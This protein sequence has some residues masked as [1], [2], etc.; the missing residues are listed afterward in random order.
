MPGLKVGDRLAYFV[1][2]SDRRPA[3][4]VGRS[5]VRVTEVVTPQGWKEW[6]DRQRTIN[7][8][9]KDLRERQ[10]TEVGPREPGG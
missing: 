3:A 9:I 6:R 4:L 8:R 1:E 10:D 5:P 7:A 2:V